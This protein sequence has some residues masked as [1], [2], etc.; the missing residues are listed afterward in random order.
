MN[1]EQA[2]PRSKPHAFGRPDLVLD[3]TG[4]AREKH[5]GR[6][7]CN[8]DELDVFWSQTRLLN[9][10]ERGLLREVGCRRARVDDMPLSDA[11]TLEDPFVGCVDQLLKVGVGQHPRR[12]IGRK[13]RDA[14]LPHGAL[15]IQATAMSRH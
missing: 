2:A 10:G 14:R 5:V 11:R 8:D 9:S 6:G 7:G 3:Q 12:N 1:P 15:S 13:R 4:G